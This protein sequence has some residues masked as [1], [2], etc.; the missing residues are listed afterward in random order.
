[1][2]PQNSLCTA[3]EN[4]ERELIEQALSATDGN[5]TQAAVI[6]QICRV[7]IYQR[8][9]RL[10]IDYSSFRTRRDQRKRIR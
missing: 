3:L 2:D 5:V 1:M 8:M 6:M 4:R 7:H 10:H 9:R